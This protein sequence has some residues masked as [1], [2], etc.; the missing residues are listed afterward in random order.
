MLL[1]DVSGRLC[2]GMSVDPGV[3]KGHGVALFC[4]NRLVE[5]RMVRDLSTYLDHVRASFDIHT[6][7]VELPVIR[8]TARQK[9]RQSDIVNLS[10]AVGK[11]IAQVCQV[12]PAVQIVQVKPEEWKGQ[13]PKRVGVE[14]VRGRLAAEELEMLP[15]R[16]TTDV[17]DAIGI[18][19]HAFDR[20]RA[21]R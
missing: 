20:A 12:F 17:F 21:L 15:L 7:I 4:G 1:E 8:Q 14:R 5:A 13:L 18:G 19:F 9:G 11:V 6:L 10:V 16:P 3:H 2:V